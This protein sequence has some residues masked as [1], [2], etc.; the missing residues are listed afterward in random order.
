LPGTKKGG[1]YLALLIFGF[2]YSLNQQLPHNGGLTHHLTFSQGG[3]DFINLCGNLRL[4]C[5]HVVQW[6]NYPTWKIY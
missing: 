4:Y 6:G 5:S 2:G 1:S 3:D